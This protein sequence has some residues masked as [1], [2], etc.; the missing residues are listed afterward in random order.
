MLEQLETQTNPF[1][2]ALGYYELD[3]FKDIS[4][5]QFLSSS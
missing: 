2:S 3:D 1:N 5:Y 4:H